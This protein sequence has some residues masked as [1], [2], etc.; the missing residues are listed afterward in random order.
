MIDK[1]LELLRK[2]LLTKNEREYLITRLASINLLS[3]G[4]SNAKQKKG[5]GLGYLPYILY[6]APVD[7]AQAG[8]NICPWASEGCKKSCLYSAGRGRFSNVQKARI[9]RT[10]FFIKFRDQ[11]ITKLVLE[12][13][14]AQVEARHYGLKLCVR[15]NGTSDLPYE[16]YTTTMGL[17][18]FQTFPDVIFYDYTKSVL[19]ALWSMNDT[20]LPGYFRCNPNYY[21]VF[22]ASEDNQTE[23]MQVLAA[24]GKVS[25]VFSGKPVLNDSTEFKYMNEYSVHD[26]DKHDFTF[27]F[28]KGVIALSAKGEAKKDRSGF[29]RAWRNEIIEGRIYDD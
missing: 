6:L 22:S 17:T 2:P 10:L 18:I 1:D 24:G 26:G 3:R 8:I 5:E 7:T 21:L 4:A 12:I 16:R 23:V 28:E 15:L 11:F 25:M 9:R 14:V 29:V 20:S 19:R 13:G 27:L